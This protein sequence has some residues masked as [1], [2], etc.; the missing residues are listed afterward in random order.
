MCQ[1]Q[2]TN[3][4]VS[5]ALLHLYVKL[6]QES[7]GCQPGGKLG[8][9]RQKIDQQPSHAAKKQERNSEDPI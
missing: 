7:K 3:Q 9:Q 2:I 1:I 4:T 8:I 5:A 6:H